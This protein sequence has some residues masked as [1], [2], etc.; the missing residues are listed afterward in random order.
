MEIYTALK[1]PTFTHLINSELKR[2]RDFF[3]RNHKLLEQPEI[4]AYFGRWIK[5]KDIA[6]EFGTAWKSE[7]IEQML[8]T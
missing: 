8:G 6:I 5:D 4:S 1:N 2:L 3:Y 7:D